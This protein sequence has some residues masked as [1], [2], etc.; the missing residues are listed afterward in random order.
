M[1]LLNEQASGG[2]LSGCRRDSEFKNPAF[3]QTFVADFSGNRFDFAG[4]HRPGITFDAM[5]RTFLFEDRS[6]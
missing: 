2:E 5:D 1:Y 3:G 4:K 6:N